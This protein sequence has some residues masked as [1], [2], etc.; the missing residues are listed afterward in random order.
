MALAVHYNVMIHDIKLFNNI[1]SDLQIYAKETLVIPKKKAL[2]IDKDVLARA[3]TIASGKLNRSVSQ[4]SF[5]DDN[6]LHYLE[7]QDTKCDVELTNVSSLVGRLG[8]LEDNELDD[9][10]QSQWTDQGED[11]VQVSFDRSDRV[12]GNNMRFSQ[13]R[14][15]FVKRTAS[16]GQTLGKGASSLGRRIRSVA[17]APSAFRSRSGNYADLQRQAIENSRD[18]FMAIHALPEGMRYDQG[19]KEMAG[20]SPA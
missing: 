3:A 15:G 6:S 9:R 14:Q 2:P 12:Y 16:L 20:V 1:M 10:L 19:L 7:R 5:R 11:K 18:P 13:V 4:S 8:H 17:A